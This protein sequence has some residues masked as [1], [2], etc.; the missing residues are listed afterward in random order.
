L[1][2]EFPG[3]FAP[4][5]VDGWQADHLAELLIPWSIDFKVLF[6]KMESLNWMA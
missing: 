3:I 2:C 1:V 4:P 5:V 6:N